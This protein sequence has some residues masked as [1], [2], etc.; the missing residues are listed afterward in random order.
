MVLAAGWGAGLIVC[1]LPFS[2]CS[3]YELGTEGKLAFSTLYVEPV[4]NHTVLPQAQAIISTQVRYAFEKD[5]RVSIVNSP[6]AADATLTIVITDYHRDVAAVREVDTGLASKFNLTLGVLCTLTDNRDRK[7]FFKGRS[8]KVTRE[9][10]TDNGVP[11]S[12]A[13][14]NQLQSE[15]NTLPLLAEQLADQVSHTVLDVW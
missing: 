4:Q 7:D 1:A 13:V 14:G 8:I 10:F 2:G 5:A 3:H 9:A 15:Y 6:E 12:S 11:A